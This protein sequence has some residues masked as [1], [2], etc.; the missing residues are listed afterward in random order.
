[1]SQAHAPHSTG[2]SPSPDGDGMNILKIVVI[3]VVS[4]VIFAVSAVIAALILDVDETA[5]QAKGIAPIPQDILKKEEIGIIDY[6]Q[7][8]A[9]TRLATWRADK[10]QK[11][12]SYGWVDRKKGLIHIPIADAVKDVIR[13]ASGAGGGSK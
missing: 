10:E 13:Q 7:F 2:A 6:T 8:D 9:D 5:M 1:M 4:L 3:G 11:L 12:A